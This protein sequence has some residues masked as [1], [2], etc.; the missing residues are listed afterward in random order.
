MLHNDLETILFYRILRDTYN[1]ENWSANGP[2]A[3]TKAANK[4]CST[5]IVN[6]M[7]RDVCNGFM[8]YPKS[9][10]F[11]IDWWFYKEAFLE[12]DK[13]VRKIL[14]IAMNN[15]THLLHFNNNLSH[16]L[17]IFADKMTGYGLVADMFCPKVYSACNMYF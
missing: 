10:F 8:I 15:N 13:K 11:G 5:R 2:Q 17:V 9:Y 14:R 7:T 4:H 3:L 12:D 6:K 16:G 1:P